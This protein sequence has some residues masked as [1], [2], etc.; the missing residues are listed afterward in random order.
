MNNFL[1][2]SFLVVII[3]LAMLDIVMAIFT[4]NILL[5]GDPSVHV[6]KGHEVRYNSSSPH[7]NYREGHNISR[8]NHK[9]SKGGRKQCEGVEE[10]DFPVFQGRGAAGEAVRAE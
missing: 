5:G 10:E 3:Y 6:S 9:N 7:R 2:I 8:Y 1:K 4:L